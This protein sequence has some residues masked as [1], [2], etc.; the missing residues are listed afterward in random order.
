MD[1]PAFRKALERYRP[2][3][4]TVWNAKRLAT[5]Q[6]LI[7][8]ADAQLAQMSPGSPVRYLCYFLDHADHAFGAE[9]F[10][11]TSD[12][13]AIEVARLLDVP[14]IGG[15]FDLYQGGRLVH[16]ERRPSG[17]ALPERSSRPGERPSV[18]HVVSGRFWRR[19]PR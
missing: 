14:A 6:A 4:G 15:G 9:L 10:G 5:L 7:A 3:M 13:E 2:I 17:K 18:L 12:D 19:H 8:E 11:S 16:R 1:A